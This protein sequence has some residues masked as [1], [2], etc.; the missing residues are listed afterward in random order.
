[1]IKVTQPSTRVCLEVGDESD[2]I[3]GLLFSGGRKTGTAASLSSLWD[4]VRSRGG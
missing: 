1:M 2:T 4:S 3:S